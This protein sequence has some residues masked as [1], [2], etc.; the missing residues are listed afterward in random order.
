MGTQMIITRT[1][2]DIPGVRMKEMRLSRGLT[3]DQ[4]AKIVGISAS[5]LSQIERNV[6]RNV[7]PENFLN[8]CAYFD[9]DPFY[10]I[11]GKSKS[12][13]R[14]SVLRGDASRPLKPRQTT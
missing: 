8:F 12:A 13:V 2:I 1:S 7:R 9:A 11:F 5:A 10:V 4:M 14:E 3:L 6:T